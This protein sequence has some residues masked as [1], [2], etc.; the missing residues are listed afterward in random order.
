MGTKM[1]L[2]Y[3]GDLHV[4]ATHLQSGTTITTDAPIDNGGK[5]ASFSPTDLLATA[6]GTCVLTM[7]SKKADSMN[8]DFRG[9]RAEVE[10][11]MAMEPRRVGAVN[12]HLHLSASLDTRSR[13][14]LENTAHTCPV[15]KSL[16]AELH[17][18]F[19]FHYDQ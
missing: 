10:K 11:V 14:I 7:M 4:L 13:T 19:I 12:I 17:Q 9:S 18:N 1:H 15:A 5:G 6:L 2:E 8:I 3:Q 16:A